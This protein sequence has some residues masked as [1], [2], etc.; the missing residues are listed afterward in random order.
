MLLPTTQKCVKVAV[1]AAPARLGF[2]T[3]LQSTP[4]TPVG[5]AVRVPYGTTTSYGMVVEE[6]DYN[7]VATKAVSESFGL[8]ATPED[9][10]VAIDMAAEHLCAPLTILKRFAP[11]NH[12]G[13]KPLSFDTTKLHPSRR[14]RLAGKD[15]P[16]KCIVVAPEL[17][18]CETAAQRAADIA[19]NCSDQVL[20]LCPTVQDVEETLS[21]FEEGA[22]RLD[23]KARSGAWSGFLAG[24]VPVGVA[25]RT[26]SWYS[27]ANLATIIVVNPDHPGHVAARLP[28]LHSRDVALR[29][30]TAATVHVETVNISP[31][32]ETLAAGKLFTMGQKPQRKF[33][34]HEQ[35]SSITALRIA[36]SSAVRAKQ[37]VA[38]VVPSKQVNYICSSC[39]HYD[40]MMKQHCNKC[41]SVTYPV[42]WSSEKIRK[43]LP[44]PVTILSKVEVAAC[45]ERFDLVV[46]LDADHIYKTATFSPDAATWK[47]V[48]CAH[49]L[50]KQPQLYLTVRDP[51]IPMIKAL[52]AGTTRDAAG[53]V[54]DEASNLQLPP[55][56]ATANIKIAAPNLPEMQPPMGVHLF[57]PKS[58]GKNEWEFLMI[59]PPDSYQVARTFLKS[60]G[61]KYK[62][63]RLTVSSPPQNL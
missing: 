37:K 22:V 35:N 12:K 47:L 29:R 38:V 28:Y 42:G 33:F 63:L 3:Y 34:H 45:K 53:I 30:S 13:K 21:Y 9:I 25:T 8:R 55:F 15:S 16:D 49:R 56:G 52:M 41:Q 20:V 50:S 46:V 4:P 11:S 51:E 18:L 7:P 2:L 48:A 36:M 24:S 19:V 26:G 40:R 61:K 1:D 60:L 58:S 17:S 5:Y 43:E 6:V 14:L 27:A 10:L 44:S 31:S 32:A 59:A 54:W 39:G 23:A 62:K 57:G